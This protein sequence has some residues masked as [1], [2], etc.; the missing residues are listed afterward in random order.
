MP[1]MSDM[2]PQALQLVALTEPCYRCGGLTRGIVGVLV[3]TGPGR[4]FREFDDVALALAEVLDPKVLR[5][6]HIGPIK[7]RHSRLR[8][9]YMSN[10]CVRCDAILGSF[11]LWEALQEF[12]SEG[13]RIDD[14]VVQ[15]DVCTP[16]RQ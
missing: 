15:V 10:G 1:A 14:L 12:L 11:P 16:A 7:P 4:V 9:T 5:Q 6:A 13:G 3:N 8:G 2:S